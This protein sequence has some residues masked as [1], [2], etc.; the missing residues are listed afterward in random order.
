MNSFGIMYALVALVSWGFGDFFIQRTSRDFGIWPSLFCITGAGSIVLLPFVFGEI[1]LMVFFWPF[2]FLVAALTLVVALLE[3][4]ALQI[5]KLTVI[6]PI[7]SFELPLTV[8]LGITLLGEH[9]TWYQGGLIALVFLGILLV[10]YSGK[11]KAHHFWEHGAILALMAT[12]VMAFVNFTTGLASR[13]VG[14]VATIWFVHTV[15]AVCCILYFTYSRSWW[16]FFHHIRKHPA[17]S[18]AVALFDNCAWLA[19]SFAVILI[20]ISLAIT[21]SESYI[22]LAVMLGVVFNHERLKKYQW[23]GII[24]T[25]SAVLVLSFIS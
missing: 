18:V 24:L 12:V 22:I 11:I 20:P 25:L 5:G 2:L 4:K 10:A 6:E 14:P 15:I 3:F 19:Y 7:L 23:I 16:S 21:I 13:S 9:L 17:E 1:P 8:L